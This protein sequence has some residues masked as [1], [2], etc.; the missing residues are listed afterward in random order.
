MKQIKGILFSCFLS[1]LTSA[2]QN[3]TP[4]EEAPSLYTYRIPAGENSWIAHDQD[5]ARELITQIRQILT[6]M[7]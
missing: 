6:M 3:N 1:I 4:S 5:L 7:E 2:C